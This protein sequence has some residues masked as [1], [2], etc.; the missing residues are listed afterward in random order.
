MDA[1]RAFAGMIK[2]AVAPALRDL[3]FRGSGQSYAIPSDEHW[4]LLGFQKRTSST[5][6]RVLFTVNLTVVSKDNWAAI[7]ETSPWQPARPSPNFSVSGL[8]GAWSERIGSLLPNPTDFWW[9]IE[10]ERQVRSATA[11]I[12]EKIRTYALP[13][14]QRQMNTLQL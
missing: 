11:D 14:M 8:P 12:I 6:E 2:D 7:R 13:A 3:G 1:Q 9:E 10:S 5:R 4:A